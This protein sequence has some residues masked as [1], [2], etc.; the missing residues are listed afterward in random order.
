MHNYKHTQSS[1]SKS[2]SGSKENQKE[3]PAAFGM[4]NWNWE[5]SENEDLEN[6]SDNVLTTKAAAVVENDAI[7]KSD[8]DVKGSGS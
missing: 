4:F 3:K 7:I 5:S 1:A 2:L 8:K 6:Q